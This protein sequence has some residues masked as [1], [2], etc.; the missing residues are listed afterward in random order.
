ME[1]IPK[2]RNVPY[3]EPDLDDEPDIIVAAAI[4]KNG[5]IWTGARHSELMYGDIQKDLCVE[6]GVP[7]RINQ[8]DQGFWTKN[9]WFLNRTDALYVAKRAGQIPEDFNKVLLSENLW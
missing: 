8:E 6:I 5:H 1:T 2:L 9:G 7:V 3:V 4:R